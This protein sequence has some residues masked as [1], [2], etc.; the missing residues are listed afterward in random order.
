MSNFKLLELIL[1]ISIDL[2]KQM[3]CG[4]FAS[5][6]LPVFEQIVM[7]AFCSIVLL[8][9]FHK[10]LFVLFEFV[11]FIKKLLVDINFIFYVLFLLLQAMFLN[12]IS[13]G[14]NCEI[15]IIQLNILNLGGVYQTAEFTFHL[16][17]LIVRADC[18]CNNRV[19]ILIQQAHNSHAFIFL[20]FL[21][22]FIN[23]KLTSV[24]FPFLRSVFV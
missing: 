6:L 19:L 13:L 7:V 8:S 20:L 5:Q 1:Q 24:L 2:L 12:I 16:R 22:P 3:L 15:L 10:S 9:N 4:L 23:I 18:M 21:F 11:I 17:V 14:L